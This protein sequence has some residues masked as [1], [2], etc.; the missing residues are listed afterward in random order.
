MKKTVF[1]IIVCSLV[2]TFAGCNIENAD[3]AGSSGGNG[4]EQIVETSIIEEQDVSE[5]QEPSPEESELDANTEDISADKTIN[6]IWSNSYGW[7]MGGDYVYIDS[8]GKIYEEH[9]VEEPLFSPLGACYET[10]SGKQF[11][12]EELNEFLSIDK[13]DE[14]RQKEILS[15]KG[16]RFG[17]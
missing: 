2:M 11:T 13:D 6:V 1:A 8:D 4:S 15:K 14:E 5:I 7:A 3:N 9:E 12:E 16:I 17:L 10:Y